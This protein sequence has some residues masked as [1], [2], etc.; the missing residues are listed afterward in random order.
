MKKRY[1]TIFTDKPIKF[2]KIDKKGNEEDPKEKNNVREVK[3]AVEREDQDKG[4]EEYDAQGQAR[5]E[6]VQRVCC[7]GPGFV[8]GAR[9]HEISRFG[10]FLVNDKK[11]VRIFDGKSNKCFPENG[12]KM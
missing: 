10:D 6:G 2:E 7:P 11:V 5:R 12:P 1:V 3:C 4:L 9:G 8:V